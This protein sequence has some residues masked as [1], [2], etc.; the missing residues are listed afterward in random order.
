MWLVMNKKPKKKVTS[1]VKLDAVSS[2]TKAGVHHVL[3]YLLNYTQIFIENTF[4]VPW[5]SKMPRSMNISNTI[6]LSI[7]YNI[8]F[9]I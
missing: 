3:R 2:I 7:A 9:L 4:F 1:K 8:L 6:I 5:S